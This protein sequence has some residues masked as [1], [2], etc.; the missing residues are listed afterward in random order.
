MREA[1]GKHFFLTVV[2]PFFS[3]CILQEIPLAL[4]TV[5]N[6]QGQCP[7]EVVTFLSNLLKHNDNRLNKVVL[8]SKFNFVYRLSPIVCRT[9][10]MKINMQKKWGATCNRDATYFRDEVMVARIGGCDL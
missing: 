1:L 9:F 6:A 10:Y 8:Y 2:C 5:R 4:S 3:L 7:R